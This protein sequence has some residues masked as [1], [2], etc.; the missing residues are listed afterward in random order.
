MLIETKNIYVYVWEKGMTN[1]VGM[2]LI[3]SV[4]LLNYDG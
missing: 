4:T 1:V 2:I 3:I